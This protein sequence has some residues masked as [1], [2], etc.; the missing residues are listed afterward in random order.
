MITFK[1][2]IHILI[3]YIPAVA[4]LTVLTL[5]TYA[6]LWILLGLGG[7]TAIIARWNTGYKGD[8]LIIRWSRH[9]AMIAFISLIL[10]YLIGKI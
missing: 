2:I 8:S 1:N 7:V 5:T 6:G 4:I 9:F 10:L 3:I